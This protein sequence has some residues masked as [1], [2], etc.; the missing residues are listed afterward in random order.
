MTRLA[1]RSGAT[2]L[3]FSYDGQF[4]LYRTKRGALP[5]TRHFNFYKDDFDRLPRM[6]DKFLNESQECWFHLYKPK[7]GDVIVDVGAEI[8]TDTITFSRAVSAAGKVIAIEAQP[9]T[10]A[11]LETTCR[12]NRLTNVTLIPRAVADKPSKVKISSDAGVESNHLGDEGVIVTADSLDNILKDETHINLL[13]MNIEGA[14]RLAINGMDS[15]MKKTEYV[16][17]ACHDFVG[18]R[19][20]NNWFNPR[21]LVVNYLKENGFN[22]VTRECDPR[23]YARY[24][25]HAYSDRIA[26]RA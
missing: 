13:K 24:H 25:I 7:F 9:E 8:G 17:I 4:W 2:D 19:T 21:D 18:A 23:E 11:M 22:I 15:T 26:P 3:S 12:I 6:F 16:A 1:A 20:G 10:F 5:H 14:E